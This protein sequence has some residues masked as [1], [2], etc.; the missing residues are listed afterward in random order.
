MHG[1][2]IVCSCN[3]SSDLIAGETLSN[4]RDYRH[5]CTINRTDKDQ[6]LLQILAKAV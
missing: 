4:Q 3:W 6:L 5:Y 1:I 2:N